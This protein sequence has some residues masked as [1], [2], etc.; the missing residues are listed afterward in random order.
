MTQPSDYDHLIALSGADPESR[1]WHSG[2]PA[3]SIPLFPE[4][5]G[6]ELYRTSLRK[7]AYDLYGLLHRNSQ[8]AD[9]SAQLPRR[10]T[11][12]FMTALMLLLHSL[13][14]IA[15]HPRIVQ[16]GKTT[17]Q[18]YVAIPMGRVKFLPGQQYAGLP[19]GPFRKAV[20]ALKQFAP[21]GGQPWIEYA[22]GFYDQE[23]KQG[24]RTRIAPNRDFRDW[25]LRQ[26]LIF[27]HHPHGP[28]S[29][30][31]KAEKSLLWLTV[32][33]QFDDDPEETAKEVLSRPLLGDETIL[34]AVNAQQ[35]RL[36]IACPLP[37]Y[38][39]Y[40]RH[41]DFTKGRS[42]LRLSG[43]KQLY[44]AFSGEDGRG[45]RL[46][47]SWV[48]RVPSD[49]RRYLTIN[50]SPTT[51]LDY[52]NMQLV[53][54]YAMAGKTVP[55]GDLYQIDRQSRDWMKTVLTASVGVATKDEALGA[56]RKKLIEANQAREGRA[57]ALYDAF[58]DHHRRVYPHGEGAEAMWG[59]LQYADSQIALRVL[60]YLLEQG[61]AVVPIHDSFIV[62]AQHR[63]RLRAAMEAAWQDFWPFTRITI[64]D[65]H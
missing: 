9:G 38:R 42:N 3:N 48:Q 39:A 31:S 45:G 24:K 26:G 55:E 47:G 7:A 20:L 17:D 62:Q 65:S 2:N 22:S 8:S 32:K 36:K 64:K 25:M 44:R 23:I 14:H 16:D 13:S 40:E 59:R 37:D 52:A 4:I 58:W 19:Y 34:P 60:R 15:S 57:E 5:H 53:L 29:H 56:L 27:P 11:D 35:T 51:E 21:E 63:E 61:I 49:L 18:Q 43:S 33:A 6:N 10:P 30:K 28:N 46:Y 41:Y 12:Q 1:F 50:G 54:L